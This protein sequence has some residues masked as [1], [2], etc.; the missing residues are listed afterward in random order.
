MGDLK[1]ALP[2]G[3]SR[4]LETVI[5]QVRV[6]GV[7]HCVVVLGHRA[8]ELWPLVE[9]RGAR[10]VFN[11]RYRE[12]M[13]SSVQCGVAALPEEVGTILIAL[14][15]QPEIGAEVIRALLRAFHA[16]PRGLAVPVHQGRRGHPFLI[17]GY[18]REELLQL[19]SER[20]L[21]ELRERHPEDLLEIPVDT[22]SVLYDLDRPED[23]QAALARL[24]AGQ[25]S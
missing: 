19:H 14:G 24:Q 12:G 10:P 16:S 6:V 23:Y 18:Y 11:E 8:E 21:K 3:P 4:I 5:D 25:E 1:P 9:A 22:A 17:A 2:F 20:G 7:D 15:D 13:L